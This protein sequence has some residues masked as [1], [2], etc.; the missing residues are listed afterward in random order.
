MSGLLSLCKIL[1]RITV[2]DENGNCV[3]YRW[4]YANECPVMEADMPPGSAREAASERAKWDQIR[5][6]IE[7][8]GVLSCGKNQ[9]PSF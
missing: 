5:A 4:D 7:N 9:S 2:S 3:K 8:P 6:E 1:G